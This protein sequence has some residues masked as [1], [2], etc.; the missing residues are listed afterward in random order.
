MGKGSGTCARPGSSPEAE[1]RAKV[2]SELHNEIDTILE[3]QRVKCRWWTKDELVAYQKIKEGWI[4]CTYSDP[5]RK[6]FREYGLI[7]NSSYELTYFPSLKAAR[8]AVNDVSLEVGLN[9]DSGLTRQQY[10]A[11]KMGDSPLR[12]TKVQGHWRVYAISSALAPSL[13]KYFNS[14]QEFLDSWK[15]TDIRFAQHPPRKAAHQAVTNWLS[16]TIIEGK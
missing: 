16:Q 12:I 3:L 1:Y 10:V 14:T 13:E 6:A 9:I 5:I 15:S 2:E 4:V 11:Y 8:Q 7:S